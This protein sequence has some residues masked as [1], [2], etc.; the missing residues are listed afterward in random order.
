MLALDGCY[1]KD[2]RFF[3]AP[4]PSPEEV[5][6]ILER[7]VRRALAL[8]DREEEPDDDDLALARGYFDAST[9]RGTEKHGLPREVELPTRRKA[10]VAEFDLDAEVAVRGHDRERLAGLARYVL[11]PPLAQ[12]RISY[13]PPSIVTLELEAPWPDGT[14]HVT[15]TPH[16]FIRRLASLVPRP[17][18]NTVIYAGVLAPNASRRAAIVPSTSP[19]PR[20]TFPSLAER[21]LGVD[22]LGCRRCG[23]R[24]KLV[25][26]IHRKAE[27]RRLLEHL[28][29]WKE[30]LPI[31]PARGPP[32]QENFDFGC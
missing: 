26:V 20:H 32:R 25:A 18:K 3:T 22:I 11:R 30:P 31:H 13:S 24:M 16:A 12:T 29:M 8:L 5:Q 6:E 19:R 23:R 17:R 1:G 21:S 27:V 2:G 7:I 10:R 15:L 4:A 28:G 9:S 14:T